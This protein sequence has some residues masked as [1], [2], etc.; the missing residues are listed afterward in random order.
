MP[1]S[2]FGIDLGTSNIKI[3]AKGEEEVFIAKN[4]IAI[5]GRDNLF[6]YGDNA[7]EMYEKA[8]SNIHIRRSL[9]AL[10]PIYATA[11]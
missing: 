7:F 2:A 4:M 5:E 10:F 1:V 9:N 6:A 3:Y 11:R 8:P